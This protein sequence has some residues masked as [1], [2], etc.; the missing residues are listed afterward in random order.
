MLK[1]VGRDIWQLGLIVRF[2]LALANS[3]MMWIISSHAHTSK[4]VRLFLAVL[5]SVPY[6]H[7]FS[8]AFP[9]I[10]SFSLFHT[11]ILFT[12]PP[13][14]LHSILV[15]RVFPV[16][17]SVTES[18]LFSCR[19]KLWLGG[20]ETSPRTVAKNRSWQKNIN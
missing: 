10:F 12:N 3:H 11:V 18:Y 16:V 17:K 9:L 8:C 7:L 13:S 6:F 14:S 1:Q 2:P 20:G 15:C 5:K 4:S 19:I